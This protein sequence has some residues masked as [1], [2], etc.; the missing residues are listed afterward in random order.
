ME[1][2][3][4]IAKQLKEVHGN[5]IALRTQMTALVGNGQPGRVGVLERR[6]E[7]L[8]S[9]V[10]RWRGA[11]AVLAFLVVVLASADIWHLLYK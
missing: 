5:V 6:M 3:D 1:K 10:D 9:Q 2:L 8:Q 11:V 7:E 4:E